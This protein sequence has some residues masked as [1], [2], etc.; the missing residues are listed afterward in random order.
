LPSTDL[1]LGYMVTTSSKGVRTHGL[2]PNR[3]RRNQKASGEGCRAPRRNFSHSRHHPSG[4]FDHPD[5]PQIQR[6]TLPW[7]KKT[8]RCS[9]RWFRLGVMEVYR[10]IRPLCVQLLCRRG[11][12]RN[13]RGSQYQRF[14]P[15]ERQRTK[16]HRDLRLHRWFGPLLHLAR[17]WTGNQ[18][19]GQLFCAACSI[20]VTGGPS[21]G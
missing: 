3:I 1:T 2:E 17:R 20:L 11:A 15:L 10:T 16:L 7:G 6:F 21:G 18:L 9:L 13:S 5:R 19:H 4:R 8:T 12:G 14:E